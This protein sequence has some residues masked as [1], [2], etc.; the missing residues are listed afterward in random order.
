V[1]FAAPDSTTA[2]RSRS[3]QALLG[4]GL[5]FVLAGCEAGPLEFENVT[6]RLVLDRPD[7]PY[8]FDA[9]WTDF[10]SDGCLDPFVF[11]HADPS[12]SRLWLNPC[13]AATP[14]Q[15]VGNETAQFYIEHPELPSG[16][17]WVSLLD[18]NGDGREDFWLRHANIMAARYLNGT[19]PGAFL[20][21][22]STK[23]NGCDN[24][25]VFG[26]I[27]GDGQL[28]VIHIDRRVTDMTSGTERF[29]ATTRVEEAVIADLDG[30]G[31]PEIV[32]PGLGGF[33]LNERGRLTWVDA[34]LAG[35][36]GP[37]LSSDLDS[38]GDLDLLTVSGR[39][40]ADGGTVHL[41]RNDAMRFVRIPDA[42]DLSRLPIHAYWT[43]YGNLVAGDLDNDGLPDLIAAGFAR[44][45][46]VIVLRNEGGLRFARG[47]VDL[48][49]AGTG[50]EPFK[51]RA[52]LGDYDRDGR[53]DI[54]KTQATTNVG[55]WRNVS[56][57]GSWLEVRVRSSA[58]NRDAIGA[59]VVWR[60]VGSGAIIQSQ[61]LQIGPQHPLRSAH[62]GL[63]NRSRATLDV[64][65]PTAGP[66][67]RLRDV[68][69]NQTVLMF[70]D[71]CVLANWRV[72]T[73]LPDTRPERCDASAEPLQSGGGN[74]PTPSP[75]RTSTSSQRI[76]VRRSVAGTG[77]VLVNAGIPFPPGLLSDPDRV[78]LFDERGTEIDAAVRTTLRWHWK[79]GSARAI[80]LQFELDVPPQGRSLWFEIATTRADRPPLRPYVE[81]LVDG[82]EG[83]RIPAAIAVLSPQWL[84]SSLL[85]G[86]MLASNEKSAYDSFVA[87]QF[88]WAKSLP[89]RDPIAWL[90][91]RTTTLFKL[92]L[93][94]GAT[95]H[96]LAA[97]TSYRFYMS[98]V[99]RDGTPGYPQCAGGW[100]FDTVDACDSKFVYIQPVLYAL[101][102]T[103]DDSLHDDST[104]RKM[105]GA[106]DT[107]GWNEPA[108]PYTRVEQAFTERQAGLGLLAMVAAWELTGDP[109]H[110]HRVD[111]RIQWLYEHQTRNPDGLGNDGSWR[112]SWQRHEGSSYDARSDVRGA[113]P[114]MSE[115]IIDGLWHAWLVTNDGRAG[116]MIQAF[117]W[118]LEN[119][120]WIDAPTF[121]RAGHTWRHPCSG[122]SGQIGWYWSSAHAAEASLIA[123]QDSE[124]WYSDAHNVEL[125]FVVAA[126]RYFEP[127]P[128]RRRRYA[129]RLAALSSS[130]SR[131]CAGIAQPARRFNWNNRSGAAT[132]WLRAR[133]VAT[134]INR[135][136]TTS[137]SV[138]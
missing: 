68:A 83:V 133:E 33:W 90:F 39:V 54:V 48:G 121:A 119:H 11:A 103:G 132:S 29:P 84:S 137:D 123:I 49:A 7:S 72:G 51:A 93:R 118:Y 99:K 74:A 25:C 98:R 42:G 66:A 4:V 46:S 135:P 130:L 32:Q 128:E 63:G 126:A 5:L 12:L 95:E 106:W 58:R 3:R 57:A 62:G 40:D 77:P 110:R 127:D 82:P 34:G 6:A 102:L 50:S 75:P 92:Y 76:F 35:G 59:R 55:I 26:D 101:A 136:K 9:V 70:D 79:D 24:R 89:S 64:H 41:F 117:G 2:A 80:H 97:I 85:A 20:P 17:G 114:W 122:S 15:R 129:D 108:G 23:E 134:S 65:F 1:T 105:V 87:T 37:A 111:Q 18:A 86:P 96:L 113:S 28:D 44:D 38:D 8:R 27:D 47:S 91:D 81:G 112:H 56:V 69:A 52:A 10:N 78:R 21:R 131:D 53:L 109:E 124:G 19:A 115:N 138:P 13:T 43:N 94:T 107:G 16:A 116:A 67:F 45:P 71:G 104:I 36:L 73:A 125:M 60:E 22:F 61:E 14:F 100:A 30:N 88:D 31:W 120:G